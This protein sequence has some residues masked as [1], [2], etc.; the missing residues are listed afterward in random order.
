M[1]SCRTGF[2]ICARNEGSPRMNWL[3]QWMLRD[4]RSY[5]WRAAGTK[6]RSV[7]AHKIAQYFD[8][9]I[10]D[11]FIFDLGGGEFMSCLIEEILEGCHRRIVLMQM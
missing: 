5:L 2:R 3:T 7:L 11:I 10:E 1:E 9:K 6:P 4:R 8:M